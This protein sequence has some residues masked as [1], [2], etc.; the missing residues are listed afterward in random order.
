M[1]I[2]SSLI[3]FSLVVI[4]LPPVTIQIVSAEEGVFIAELDVCHADGSS[5]MVNGDFQWLCLSC[6]SIPLPE[7]MAFIDITYLLSEPDIIPFTMEHPP[8]A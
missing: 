8:K 4:V 7:F 2:I 1:R 3:L 6:V 5:S